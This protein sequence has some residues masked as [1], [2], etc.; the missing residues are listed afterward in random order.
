MFENRVLR[1]L[2]EP[3]RHKVRE[4]LRRLHN[5]EFHGLQSSPNIS[6]LM[7]KNGTRE[8]YDSIEES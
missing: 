6:R 7:K 5:E 3:K 4:N 2:A 1:V 8:A